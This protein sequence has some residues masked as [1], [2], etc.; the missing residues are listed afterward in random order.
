M[1]DNNGLSIDQVFSLLRLYLDWPDYI[2]ESHDQEAN[3]F[4]LWL[5]QELEEAELADVT[6]GLEGVKHFINTNPEVLARARYLKRHSHNGVVQADLRQD[7]RIPV[8]TQAFFL[9]YDCTEDPSL[10]GTIVH[11]VLI[12]IA[13]QGMRVETNIAVPAG[14]II[15]MTV[16]QT[17]SGVTLYNLT[18]EV[19]WSGRHSA[20]YH[21]GIS[22]F[23]I[24]EYEKWQEFYYFMS[25]SY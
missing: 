17:G 3:E 19:R 1:V 14:T 9:I 10:E 8:H 7:T 15:S 23:N 4:Y 16:A 24:E 20:A 21:L 5:T 12:D 11:G 6:G 22:I 25:S 13:R 18:C 2:D